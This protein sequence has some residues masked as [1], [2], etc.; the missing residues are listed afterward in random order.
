MNNAITLPTESDL[1][2]DLETNRRTRQCGSN[3]LDELRRQRLNEAT[4]ETTKNL[5]Q[6][7]E[8]I[9]GW[10]AIKRSAMETL[11]LKPLPLLDSSID[12]DMLVVLRLNSA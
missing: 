6:D 10:K 4:L 12:A 5:V 9:S 8:Y 1:L 3:Y 7:L 11:G 2:N